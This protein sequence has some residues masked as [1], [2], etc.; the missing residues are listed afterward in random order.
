M[1][2]AVD[3]DGTIDSAPTIFLGL[4]QALRAAG[5]RVVVVTGSAAPT[6]TEQDVQDKAGYLAQLG[7]G[8]AYDELVVLA[9][10]VVESKPQWL[11]DNGADLL[12][13]NKKATAKA[14]P[15]PTLVP[16]KTRE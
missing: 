16:W 3:I 2:V 8:E 4:M 6:V 12:I 11:S 15:C 1:M 10:P 5:H 9:D 7:F 14:A 13:D